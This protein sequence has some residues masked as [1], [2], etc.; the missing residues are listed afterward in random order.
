MVNPTQEFENRIKNLL[1]NYQF[2][3]TKLTLAL[4]VAHQRINELESAQDQSAVQE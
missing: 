4:E 3:I 2:E 1:G